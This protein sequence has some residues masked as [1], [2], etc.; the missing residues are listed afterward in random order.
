MGYAL[1]TNGVTVVRIKT[2]RHEKKRLTVNLCVLKLPP[3]VILDRKTLPKTRIPESKLV[4][5]ANESGWMNH[6]MI[7]I[8]V[9]IVRKS[10]IILT[11][12]NKSN[13]Y[14]KLPFI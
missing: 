3:F 6:E 12:K 11:P 2:T 8:W 9:K 10:R 7:E 13:P 1:E 14:S 4:V 5:A